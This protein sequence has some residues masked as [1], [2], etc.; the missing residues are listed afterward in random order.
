MGN[1]MARADPI[2]AKFHFT[3]RFFP[4]DRKYDESGEYTT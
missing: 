3:Q 2:R 4:G 1:G